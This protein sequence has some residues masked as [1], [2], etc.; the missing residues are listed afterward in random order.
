MEKI[1]SFKI[2]H[3]SLKRG[4]YVSRVDRLKESVTTTFDIRMR[5]PSK[6][7]PL[8]GAAMHTIEHIGATFLRN[9]SFLSERTVYFGP[10][11][12]RTGFY[13]V[14]DGECS[15]EEIRG[16]VKAL[17]RYISVFDNDIPGMSPEECGN[18]LYH[19]LIKAR[20]A[21]FEYFNEVLCFLDE[22]NTTYKDEKSQ[23]Q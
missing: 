1:E 12:C 7:N 13:L 2:D 23:T 8:D 3:R 16:T 18:F 9:S 20:A 15:V 11:G 6:R 21:A 14:I 19:D 4:L 10:M 5:E 22:S 17:F